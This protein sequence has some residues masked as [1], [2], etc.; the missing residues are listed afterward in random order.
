MLGFLQI[1]KEQLR[2]NPTILILDSNRY[3]KIVRNSQ[4]K[5]LILIKVIRR[6]RY[7]AS[8]AITCQKVYY[9][10]NISKAPLII[11]DLQQYLQR[12]EEGKLLYKVIE[13]GVVNIARYYHHKTIYIGGKDNNIFNIYKGLDITKAINY[14]LEGLIIP[15]RLTRV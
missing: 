15:L 13:K 6:I 9:K 14:K 10:G 12:E 2:F 11:K 4:T 5:R 7:I 3:I 8:R 1:N